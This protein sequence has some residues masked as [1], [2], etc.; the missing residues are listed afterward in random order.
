MK[1]LIYTHEFP[2]FLGGLATT[3]YKLSKGLNLRDN[4]DVYVLAPSY[5]K[6]DKEIDKEFEGDITRIPILRN[7]ISKFIPILYYITAAIYFFN[8]LKITKPD[9][10]LLITEEAEATGGI[11]SY[12]SK[13]RS[14]P[15]VAGSGI[16]T[17]FLGNKPLKKLLSYPISRLYG[18]SENIIAVS[19]FSRELLEKIGVDKN[20][21]TVINNGIS[22][23]F[24]TDSPDEKKVQK[25]RET[26]S[27]KPDQVVLM[28]IARILPR[29]GQDNV[30]RAL[31]IV[32]NKY[33]DFKYLIV[34]TGRYEANFK[35][36]ARSSGLED[37]VIFTGGVD[38]EEII[39]YLDLCDVFILA[40]RFWNNKVEG[41]PNAVLEASA[42]AKPVIVGNHSGSVESV[43]DGK[44]GLLVDSDDIKKIS[45][46]ILTLFS[47][48]HKS[49]KFGKEGKKMIESRFTEDIMIGNYY[50]L[51]MS[52]KK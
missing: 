46:S 32:E 26:F 42:R 30:I 28:T 27:I 8:T 7:K 15:R 33:A 43:V 48:P 5:G 16:T 21:I 31:K 50:S 11:V 19:N 29:K 17:C 37:K 44:T 3:S 14:L 40:N 4:I 10:V 25:L 36:L 6:A 41:L 35:E 38:H 18:I 34:G 9:A 52:Y 2:P 45:Q 23:R 51:F 13:F 12:F 39:H 1:I 49:S 22:S 24:I 47:D 20:K